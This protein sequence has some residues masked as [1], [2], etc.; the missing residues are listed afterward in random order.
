MINPWEISQDAFNVYEKVLGFYLDNTAHTRLPASIGADIAK[1]R[2]KY[3]A[4]DPRTIAFVSMQFHYTACLLKGHLSPLEMSLLEGCF[5]VIDDHLY[6]P[7]HRAYA[8]AGKYP[9]ESPK[10]V[11]AQKVLKFSSTI[12][13]K[14]AVEMARMYPNYKTYS[15]ALSDPVVMASSR[16]DVVIFQIYLIVCLLEDSP[17]ILQN[18][19]FPLCIM[20]YPKLNV[21]WEL[22][23]QILIMI[24]REIAHDLGEVSAA[25]FRP[26]LYVLRDMFAPEVFDD[27]ALS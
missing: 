3:T 2:K 8:A 7:L 27:L 16:R 26:Y 12:A 14:V 22:V 23:R 15:G 11:A 4:K 6:M 20:I 19:L 9:V 18:E 24:G 25:L 13:D 5:K 10:L 17:S 21:H 1:L